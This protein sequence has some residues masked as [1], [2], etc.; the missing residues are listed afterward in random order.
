MSEK[1][2]SEARRTIAHNYFKCLYDSSAA[3]KA[4]E[5]FCPEYTK[6]KASL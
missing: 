2:V 3:Y 4:N 1:A 6:G 5:T